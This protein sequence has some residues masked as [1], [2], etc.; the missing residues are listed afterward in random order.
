[1]AASLCARQHIPAAKLL[2]L[3][4]VA[5]TCGHH[6]RFATSGAPSSARN[7][8]GPA[9]IDVSVPGFVSAHRDH[10]VLR[11][12]HQAADP[13]AVAVSMVR[14]GRRVRLFVAAQTPG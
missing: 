2:A 1:M 6:T 5:V 3:L 13:A 7:S 8:S 12:V 10:H 11:L 4:P 14:I 9:V